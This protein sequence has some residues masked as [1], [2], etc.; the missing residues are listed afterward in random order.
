LI[1]LITLVKPQLSVFSTI[2]LLVSLTLTYS[3]GEVF[4]HLICKTLPPEKSI[5]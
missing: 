4:D 1:F 3:L 5:A 2:T